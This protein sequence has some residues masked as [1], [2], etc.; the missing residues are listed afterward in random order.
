MKLYHSF[1]KSRKKEHEFLA[2]LQNRIPELEYINK[3]YR[4][5]EKQYNSTIE[6]APIIKSLKSDIFLPRKRKLICIETLSRL[7]HEQ[8]VVFESVN[9][10]SFDFTIETKDN[11]FFYELHE[12]QHKSLSVSRK[13]KIFDIHG[14]E[15]LVPRYLVRLL[16]DICRWQNLKNYKIIWV[17]WFE[18]HSNEFI[19]ILET[20]NHELGI[21]NTFLFKN[22]E[23]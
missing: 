2:F 1:N 3:N 23:L 7:N 15:I 20:G 17:D 18:Q 22:L 19:N 16:K 10:I 12:N 6:I 13:M 14:N 5:S 21:S 9:K 8:V 4:I 11:L